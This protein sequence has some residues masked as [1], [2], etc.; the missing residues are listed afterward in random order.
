MQKTQSWIGN[1]AWSHCLLQRELHAQCRKPVHL[2][3]TTEFPQ[4]SSGLPETPAIFY[5]PHLLHNVVFA[6]RVWGSVAEKSS[7]AELVSLKE[8]KSSEADGDG[9]ISLQHLGKL[10]F[11]FFFFFLAFLQCNYLE[12]RTMYSTKNIWKQ[13]LSNKNIIGLDFKGMHAAIIPG[14]IKLQNWEKLWPRYFFS[15]NIFHFKSLLFSF[16]FM[17]HFVMKGALF[18]W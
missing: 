5:L 17:A 7:G 18:C 3:S 8:T 10:W 4:T 9:Y 13:R 2:F 1:S 15:W 16:F 12:N 14:C 6:S 11:N